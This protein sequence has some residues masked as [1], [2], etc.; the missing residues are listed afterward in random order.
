MKKIVFS[1]IVLST[2]LFAEANAQANKTL[3]S[4]NKETTIKAARPVKGTVFNIDPAQST[5]AW[6]G[7]KVTGEHNGN[8]KISEGNIQVDGNKVVGGTVLMDMNSITNLDLTDKSY[9]QKLIDHLKSDDFFS[10]AKHPNAKFTISNITPIKGA[11][12]GAA[13]YT[14]NG[15][16]TIKGITNPVSF[17]ANINMQG[18]TVT[19]KSDAVTLDRTKWDIRYGSKSFFANIGDKAIYDDFTVQFNLVAK[20]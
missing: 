1:A 19:A 17:P 15:N 7:K 2:L 20:K 11:K 10:T 14:V 8:V 18:N 3:A 13:N 5:M 4:V 6:N 12:A 9:N 16:L